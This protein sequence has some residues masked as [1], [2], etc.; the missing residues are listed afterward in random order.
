MLRI[1]QEIYLNFLRTIVPFGI[2]NMVEE[3][4]LA[5]VLLLVPSFDNTWIINCVCFVRVPNT[6]ESSKVES[7]QLLI[8]NDREQQS[9]F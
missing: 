2:M 5:P 4:Y 3:N 6:V 8:D 9:G 1:W 7:T